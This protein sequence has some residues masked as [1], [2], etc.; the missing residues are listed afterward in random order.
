MFEGRGRAIDPRNLLVARGHALEEINDPS[1]RSWVLFCHFRS[2]L[3]ANGL[4]CVGV[5]LPCRRLFSCH[6]VA[7]QLLQ[8]GHGIV[9]P[10]GHKFSILRHAVCVCIDDR[11][12]DAAGAGLA[13]S[14]VGII[15]GAADLSNQISEHGRKLMG[16]RKRG[17]D[18]SSSVG[19][20]PFL[21]IVSI[22]KLFRFRYATH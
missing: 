1:G 17:G 15:D 5:G 16:S 19:A 4:D 22:S 13:C 9:Q 8:R 6:R 10:L 20:V 14:P 18:S 12:V 2:Q 7:V 11:G 3:V 21:A